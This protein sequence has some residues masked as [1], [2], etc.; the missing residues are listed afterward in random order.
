VLNRAVHAAE[1]TG[2]GGG[3]L[4]EADSRRAHAELRAS[5]HSL[6]GLT[7]PSGAAVTLTGS[8]FANLVEIG[9]KTGPR[10]GAG[11]VQRPDQMR[12]APKQ[13]LQGPG[14]AETCAVDLATHTHCRSIGG[15]GEEMVQAEEDIDAVSDFVVGSQQ[16]A[17]NAGGA[18]ARSAMPLL[19]AC[20]S[21]ADR[22][23]PDPVNGRLAGPQP[24]GLRNSEQLQ[25]EHY[26]ECNPMGSAI[27][28]QIDQARP[29]TDRCQCRDWMHS[30]LRHTLGGMRRRCGGSWKPLSPSRRCS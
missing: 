23:E 9:V 24:K 8:E 17:A 19:D 25:A 13:S 10:G 15:I 16:S 11:A 5:L 28:R 20:L 27:V 7:R 29:H 4:S 1:Q 22:A 2:T 12:H 6:A 30:G 3:A 21:H 26:S 18:S 14:E